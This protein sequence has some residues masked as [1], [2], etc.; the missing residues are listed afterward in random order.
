MGCI[1][2]AYRFEIGNGVFRI[3]KDG[4]GSRKGAFRASRT[5]SQCSTWNNHNLCQDVVISGKSL[6]F[7]KL[8]QGGVR[9]I[10]GGVFSPQLG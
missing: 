7:T 6:S 4:K 5:T 2:F 8:L 10:L 3:Y 9:V 1:G